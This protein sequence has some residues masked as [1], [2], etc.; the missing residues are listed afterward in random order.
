LKSFWWTFCFNF[1]QILDEIFNEA[2]NIFLYKTNAQLQR[3]GDEDLR[4]V[5]VTMSHPYTII[6]EKLTTST[7]L[8]IWIVSP[9]VGL[10]VL[11]LVSYTLY[12]LGFFK[13]AQK[14]ELE[15]LTRESRN[16]TAEEAEELKTLNA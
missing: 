10:L 15:K 12:R 3:A 7:P 2:Q 5:K 8:W 4:S 13:R 16:I 6:Y 1:Y 9:M 11:I 14:E